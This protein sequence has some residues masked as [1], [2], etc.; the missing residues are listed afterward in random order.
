MEEHNSFWPIL[1]KLVIN[2]FKAQSLI[3]FQ[4]HGPRFKKKKLQARVQDPTL[5]F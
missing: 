5:D 1:E 2:E 4:D 3:Y